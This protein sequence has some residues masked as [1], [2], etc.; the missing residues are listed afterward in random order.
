MVATETAKKET[1]LS[2]KVPQTSGPKGAPHPVLPQVT[3]LTLPR[4]RGKQTP[5][6]SSGYP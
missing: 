6:Q 1:L 3:P 4:D 2:P 5:S